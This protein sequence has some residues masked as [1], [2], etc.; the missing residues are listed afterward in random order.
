[1]KSVS[2]PKGTLLLTAVNLAIRSITML[3]QVYLSGAIGAAGLGLMQLISSVCMLGITLGSFG[4][5]VAAMYLIAE[6]FGHGRTRGVAEAVSACLRLGL[7]ASAICGALLA[8][9]SPQIASF[10]LGDPDAAAGLLLCGVFLPVTCLNSV[11]TGYYTACGKLRRMIAVELLERIVS[12]LLTVFLLC[13]SETPAEACTA[14]FASSGLAGL[15]SFLTLYLLYRR[16]TAAVGRVRPGSQ[17][18]FRLRRLALPLAANDCLRSGLSTLEHLLI[19]YGLVRSGLTH[20]EAMTAYGTVHGMA[21][22][23]LMF[24]AVILWSLSDILVP[25]LSRCRAEGRSARIRYLTGRSLRTA[26]LFSCTV[27]GFLFSLADPLGML[28]F[29]SAEAG[30]YITL[31]A[32]MVPV[33]YMDAIVDGMHKGLGQQLSCVRYNTLTSSLEIVLL[34]IL[35]PRFGVAGYIQSFVLTH[36]LNFYL[37]IRR[38]IV[39]AS[40]RISVFHALRVLLSTA[41]AVFAVLRLFG[42]SGVALPLI[43]AGMLYLS[44]LFLLFLL[45]GVLR[46]VGLR[47][48]LP[49]TAK[50]IP[51]AS[52]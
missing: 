45:T 29:R 9:F 1:M 48:I 2:V 26:L 23:T 30:R 17:M 10:C 46:D 42:S 28:L 5:R 6:E 16:E 35:L 49:R 14:I 38:L 36:V 20:S 43:P 39:V 8:A 19:P 27:G 24:C 47:D 15:F 4:T 40:P 22:P 13:F 3:F 31:L 41:A 18:R 34:L 52:A 33:L 50:K 44:L 37:S 32:P 7:A 11:M 12:I 21:F 51:R 25:E